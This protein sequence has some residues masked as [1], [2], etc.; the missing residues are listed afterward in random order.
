MI[1]AWSLRLPRL[2]DPA[3]S[4]NKA[5]HQHWR[6]RQTAAKSDVTYAHAFALQEGKLP[7]MPWTEAWVTITFSKRLTKQGAAYKRHQDLDNLGASAKSFIDG[8]VLAGILIDDSIIQAI[9]YQWNDGLSGPATEIDIEG[10]D[11]I[12]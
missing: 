6:K 8:I 3:L 10:G 4:P 12:T 1:T 11:G 2:P 7:G 5:S 9:T